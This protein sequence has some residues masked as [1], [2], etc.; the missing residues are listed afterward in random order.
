M[1]VYL[2]LKY[3]IK[4]ILVQSFALLGYIIVKILLFLV[5]ANQQLKGGDQMPSWL[6]IQVPDQTTGPLISSHFFSFRDA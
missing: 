2:D 5:G 3:R 6:D 4:S 1:L